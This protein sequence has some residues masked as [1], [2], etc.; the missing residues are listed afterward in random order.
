MAPQWS[1][2]PMVVEEMEVALAGAPTAEETAP[3]ALAHASVGGGDESHPAGERRDADELVND[4]D[5][6]TLGMH[7]GNERENV[8]AED[9]SLPDPAC[10]V[11]IKCL[12][13]NWGCTVSGRLA[14]RRSSRRE[15][16]NEHVA[17]SPAVTC[18]APASVIEFVA[19]SPAVAHATPTTADT[20]RPHLP[21]P[22]Q[23]LIQ[24][25]NMWLITCRLCGTS[26]VDRVCGIR[27]CRYLHG[28]CTSDRIRG[29]VSCR[30]L[31][32]T[33]SSDRICAR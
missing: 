17:S 25:S 28:V 11:Q 12:G 20:W 8:F 16:T 24:C 23:R 14:L 6:A 13:I 5:D 3:D 29:S 1:R 18:A 32:S 15:T 30:H 19:P 4:G 27:T 10:K 22:M 2:H 33:S 31:R 21:M 26:S 7:K 9:G